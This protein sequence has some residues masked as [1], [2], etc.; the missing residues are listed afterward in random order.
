MYGILQWQPLAQQ[1]KDAAF[2]K[3]PIS[4]VSEEVTV[5]LNLQQHFIWNNKHPKH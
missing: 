1:E 2:L 4:H 3:I 5:P